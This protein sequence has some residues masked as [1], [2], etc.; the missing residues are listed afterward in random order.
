MLF[1]VKA[2]AQDEC[3]PNWN[4]VSLPIGPDPSG[5]EFQVEFCYKCG[6]TGAGPGNLRVKNIKPIHPEQGCVAPDSEVWLINQLLKFYGQNCTVPPCSTNCLEVI[7][8]KP[9]C[10]Q[11]HT[12]GYMVGDDYHYYSWEEVCL[13]SGYCQ[14]T[15]KIC[16]DY[17]NNN[18]IISCPGW[19]VTYQE[20][21]V[22]CQE[23]DIEEPTEFENDFTGEKITT[24]CFQLWG[25]P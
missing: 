1:S 21:D 23:D 11:W 2:M 3:P 18:Q 7:V 19:V 9:L 17:Q 12:F 8:D 14:E 25:C 24:E 4:Y 15:Y 22:N 6:I 13:G 20:F 16:R 10:F 5:C